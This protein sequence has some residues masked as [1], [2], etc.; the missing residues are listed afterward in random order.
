LF[1]AQNGQDYVVLIHGLN[2]QYQEFKKK[3]QTILPGK[4]VI[5]PE[6]MKVYTVKLS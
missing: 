1:L 2:A 5:I 4:E 6:T 3:A